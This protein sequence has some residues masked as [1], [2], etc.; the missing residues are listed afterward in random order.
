MY[1][2]VG[3]CLAAI[4][5]AIAATAPNNAHRAGAAVIAVGL[6]LAAYL[7]WRWSRI[8]TSGSG[9]ATTPNV[10][11]KRFSW[12]EIDSFEYRFGP[13]GLVGV[14]RLYLVVKL[15]SGE[16]F[17]VT[18]FGSAPRRGGESYVAKAVATLNEELAGQDA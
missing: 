11:T 13:A 6:L 16:L 3:G 12:S 1:M 2:L 9:I 15:R 7:G 5:A 10:A 4:V 14:Q 18:Q 17:P 8:V